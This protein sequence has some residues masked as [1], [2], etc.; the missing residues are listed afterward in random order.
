M[1]EHRVVVTGTSVITSLGGDLSA[2]W[3][4]INIDA[5]GKNSDQPVST[6]RH[7][8]F[9]AEW[10]FR[11]E[12]HSVIDGAVRRR[13][14]RFS[15]LALACADTAVAHAGIDFS[16]TDASRAGVVMGS[17]IG[18]QQ[19]AV[20][21]LIKLRE[22][23]P[24]RV[25]AFFIPSIMVNSAAGN[26]A[27]A[28]GLGGPSMGISTDRTSA[29]QAIGHGLKIIRSGAADIMIC[30]AAEAPMKATAAAGFAKCEH[31]SQRQNSSDSA[32][33]TKNDFTDRLHLSEGAGVLVL[34]SLES[35]RL[36]D[37]AILAEVKGF[38]HATSVRSNESATAKSAVV[39]AITMAL[40]DA[41]CSPGDVSLIWTETAGAEIPESVESNALEY[42]FGKPASASNTFS[43][44]PCWGDALAASGA[45]ESVL[46]VESLRRQQ[47]PA[48]GRTGSA[49]TETASDN[50][51]VFNQN[52]P[53]VNILKN[54]I[55]ES[56][57][58]VSLLLS[59]YS[60]GLIAD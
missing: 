11:P 35:A 55:G 39:R 15:L 1:R 29:L 48:A 31:T 52:R 8:F 21:Q 38:G 28:L 41:N 36:R 54:S 25:S 46:C 17:G 7:S 2:L 33:S 5:C 24:K 57:V 6:G 32:V 34:E 43:R 9:E 14:D 20:Q 40:S 58:C 37:A 53:V 30:G 16:V 44:K 59:E 18:G 42:M 26:I 12:A 4:K 23:G 51:A 27:V 47:F 50:D 13:Y 10:N 45:I 19:S 3:D 60:E 49:S 22:R 56:G